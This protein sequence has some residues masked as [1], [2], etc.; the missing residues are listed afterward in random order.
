MFSVVYEI[1][2]KTKRRNFK[3]D[4]GEAESFYNKIKFVADAVYLYNGDHV[5]EEAHG[6]EGALEPW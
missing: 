4:L 3:D 2:R 1:N 6:C 5:E